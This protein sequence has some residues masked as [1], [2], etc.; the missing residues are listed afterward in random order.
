MTVM[1]HPLDTLLRDL[2][3]GAT[4]DHDAALASLIDAPLAVLQP[5]AESLAVDG[6]GRVISY[7][8][9]VFIPLTQ[10]CRNV[11]HYCTFAHRP[12]HLPKPYLEPDDVLAI[13]QAGAEAGCRE[14][15]FTLGDKPELRYAVA[16]DALSRLGH[17]TTVDYLAQV[18]QAVQQGSGLLP[19]V[20]CGVLSEDELRQLRPHAVSMGLMLESASQRLCERGGPHY[21]SPDKMPA[22]LPAHPAQRRAEEGCT[23]LTL[24]QREC[25]RAT[26][27]C[28]GKFL[29]GAIDERVHAGSQMQ[30]PGKCER[31]LARSQA[32]RSGAGP[33]PLSTNPEPDRY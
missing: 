29:S 18:A 3:N 27:P 21:R 24:A 14:A 8:R 20:N 4:L 30:P 23:D 15:L 22:A 13:A 7:S 9:K 6:F 17:A 32:R 31:A 28:D 5:V 19:H 2:A 1:Q 11:C 25:C 10:L 12:R 26:A 33:L 16:R